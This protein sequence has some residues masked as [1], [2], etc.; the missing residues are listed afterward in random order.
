MNEYCR[1]TAF[2]CL[3]QGERWNFLSHEEK[4]VKRMICCQQAMWG[5]LLVLILCIHILFNLVCVNSLLLCFHVFSFNYNTHNVPQLE[6]RRSYQDNVYVMSVS[7]SNFSFIFEN[8]WEMWT[9]L[10]LPIN[11][12]CCD[13]E[14]A[15][16]LEENTVPQLMN[17]FNTH[18]PDLATNQNM[19]VSPWSCYLCY[20]YCGSFD[21]LRLFSLPQNPKPQTKLI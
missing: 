20:K 5:L 11:L 2:E 8:S 17:T 7:S 13:E 14:A 1:L 9:L 19:L 18:D 21:L 12:R 16:S 15:L 10:Q 4:K 6:T 3:V